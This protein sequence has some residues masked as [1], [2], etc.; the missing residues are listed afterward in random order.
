MKITV[1]IEQA[2]DPIAIMK[3]EGDINASNFMDVVDKAEELYNNPARN[4]I[5]DLSEVSSI[6]R[7]FT[8]TPRN[9]YRNG[10]IPDC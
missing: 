5:I 8:G 7:I 10:C 2:E 4:L 3:L 9:L 1:S 6:S